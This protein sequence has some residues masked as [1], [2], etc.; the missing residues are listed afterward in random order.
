MLILNRRSILA[1]P[2]PSDGLFSREGVSFLALILLLTLSGSILIGSVLPTITEV[3]TGHRFE[4]GPEWFDR[5]TGPQFAV[6][7]LMMGVCPL[8]G[9]AAVTMRQ[10]CGRGL[11]A[12]GGAALVTAIAALAGFTQPVSL[13]GFFV[14]GLAGATVL[15]EYVRDAV[16]H[17]R[18]QGENVFRALVSLFGRNRRRYSGYLV[19]VGVVLMAL[20]VVGTRLY[21]FETELVLTPGEPVDVQDYT[22]V[23]EELQG[24]SAEDHL[25]VR[26]ALAI[27]RN[28]AYLTTLRPR[29]NQYTN[30]G[31]TVAIPALWAGLKEDLYLVL[32]GWEGNGDTATV[33]AFVNPLASFL[34]L[35]GLVFLAGGAVALWLPARAARLPIPQ[36]RRRALIAAG[37]LVTGVAVFI[38]AAVAMWGTNLE[39]L[40]LMGRPLLGQP[41]PDFTLDLLDG[42]TFTL[43]DLRGQVVVINFWATWCPPCEDEMPDL[44]TV[45]EE[46]Q[47]NG[48]VFVGIA[49]D[50]EESAVRDMASRYG[51]TYALGLEAEGSISTAYGITG[52]PETFVVDA[53]GNVTHVY[54]GPVTADELREALDG[55]L[56]V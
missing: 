47:A 25:S 7:M 53:D 5:V 54:I 35:G 51:A 16:A 46:Y 22:L 33:K 48:V 36:A 31:Q 10:L 12:L 1:A 30:S 6:L 55:L 49:F 42:S 17:S 40:Q 8:L 37:G 45:W 29:L 13:V 19:H 24:E 28:N 56:E 41:A 3:F 11:P 27:Y 38:V 26:A 50:D 43:S 2:C 21:A 15:T 39:A 44:Q 14:I 32:A 52:V 4:A 20:G 34:W 18:R 9:R 23:Y